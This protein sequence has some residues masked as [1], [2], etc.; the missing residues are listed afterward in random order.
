MPV[1]LS[2]TW[3]LS[4]LLGLIVFLSTYPY[5]FPVDMVPVTLDRKQAHQVAE[6]YLDE[7][8]IPYQN[9]SYK[10]LFQSLDPNYAYLKEQIGTK[11]ARDLI[12]NERISTGVWIV[13]W[14]E[15]AAPKSGRIIQVLVSPQGEVKS[16]NNGFTAPMNQSLDDE[17]AI[18]KA[19]D[20]LLRYHNLTFPKK[21][22]ERV[23]SQREGRY[24]FSWYETLV[25]EPVIRNHFQ[26][27][28]TGRDISS[29]NIALDIPES[30]QSEFQRETSFA[31]MLSFI[32]I[33][34]AFIIML[35]LSVIFLGKYHQGE[36]GIRY[37]AKLFWWV[38]IL[39]GL[40]VM[41]Q[42]STMSEG[43]SFGQLSRSQTT[44]LI[45]LFSLFFMVLANAV[46]AF[47]CWTVGES[48]TRKSEYP[49]HLLSPVDAFFNGK[50]ST[51]ELA[52]SIVMGYVGCFIVLGFLG[53]TGFLNST[54]F[55]GWT[56][57]GFPEQGDQLFGPLTSFQI[58][59]GTLV[60]ALSGAIFGELL[61]RFFFYSFFKS[62]FKKNVWAI[63]SCG[64]I[65][66]ISN[67]PGSFFP[68]SVNY[69]TSFFLGIFLCVLYL[70]TSLI[71][72]VLT[73]FL[74]YMTAPT[75]MLLASD[76]FSLWLEGIM[77][78]CLF[79]VPALFAISGFI[80]REPFAFE[81]DTT[82]SHIR[83][84][85]ERARISRELE[86]A[87]AVQMSMLPR[88]TPAFSGLDIAGLCVP[89]L[90]VGGDY[91]EYVPLNEN[92]LGIAIGD[93]SGK[94]VPAAIYMTL[95]KGVLLSY[96]E[97]RQDPKKVLVKVNQLLYRNMK[98]GHFVSMVYAIL[99]Q[100]SRKLSFVR[101][102]HNPV[103]IIRSN[104]VAGEQIESDG[105]A[106]G[107]DSGALF[108]ATL[109]VRVLDF[110]P[111]DLFVFYTDGLSEAMNRNQELFGE[112]MLLK[113]IAK[114][115]CQGS[116]SAREILD[117]VF[118]EVHSFLGGAPPND[119]MTMVVVKI[120]EHK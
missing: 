85:T 30:F 63:L 40:S 23:Y 29:F 65:Y 26:L 66:M 15:A 115:N 49:S 88:E 59:A 80:K 69:I 106:L 111:G 7:I 84:I 43:V 112:D 33:I 114:Y 62:N 20:F 82:P 58:T 68:H 32:R 42:I 90:E 9:L 21:G 97:T 95:T 86:I 6:S 117:S 25:N 60:T 35:L 4:G 74:Y 39:S 45:L 27:A 36:I 96:A 76:N 67:T 13:F 98:R 41:D 91:F 113:T 12:Q 38:L 71:T 116:L 2:K 83:R 57:W 51:L 75:V 92:C 10:T 55:N 94:G 78:A 87:K 16:F 99:D 70:R 3:V 8:G 46:M 14:Y 17:G 108:E 31:S 64:L 22:V 37:G 11:P 109:K 5:L 101:A 61:Y 19:Q 54:F 44:L 34:L 120:K 53:L 56:S 50:R 81:P 93:V 110:E 103:M 79:A 119:D 100:K 48:E 28:L 47:L 104:S 102:G 89:A 118:N 107:L 24:Q 73:M 72:T 18:L 77:L 105:M 52:H 1:K